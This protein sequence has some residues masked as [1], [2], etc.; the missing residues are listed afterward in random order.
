MLI[1][2]YT[3]IVAISFALLALGFWLKSKLV[4]FGGATILFCISVMVFL[5]L[6]D[7]HLSYAIGENRTVDGNVTAIVRTEENFDWT[8]ELI[9]AM[10]MLLVGLFLMFVIWFDDQLD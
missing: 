3:I 9:I 6:K 10:T 8:T 2:T 7:G 5:P 1:T 4:M